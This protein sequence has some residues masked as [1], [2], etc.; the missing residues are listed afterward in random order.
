MTKMMTARA[1]FKVVTGVLALQRNI[2][3]SILARARHDCTIF[4]L[5]SHIEID[6]T[7]IHARHNLDTVIVFI[8]I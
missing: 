3:E 7:S 4:N 1:C 8:Q 2:S 6:I 5:L